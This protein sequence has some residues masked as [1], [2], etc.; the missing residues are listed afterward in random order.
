MTF[1]LAH[2]SDPHLG[3]LPT[4]RVAEL[5]GKRILGFTNWQRRRRSDH[6]ADVLAA[7]V[8]DMRQAAPDHVAVTGDLI[9][10]A[11]EAEFAPAARWLAS[12][13]PAADVT[14]V[15]GNHD[16]YVR[17]AAHH[18]LLHWGSH[19]GHDNVEGAKILDHASHF[20][21]LRRRGPVA[22]IGLST[23]VP[24]APFLATGWLGA[25]QVTRLADLLG[26]LAHEKLFRVVLI[27]HPPRPKPSDRTKH[28]VDAAAFRRVIAA[29]G[30]DLILHGHDHVHALSWLD[31]PAGRVPAVGVPSASGAL[32]GDKDPAGYNLYRID[33]APG[34]W[35]CEAISRGLRRGHDGVV[36]L[37]RRTLIGEP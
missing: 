37:A 33:G 5:A 12:L 25:G 29:H 8:A 19:M 1:V 32:D 2:L 36:D 3:P 15:P 27:H 10:I 11:L 23:A 21:F 30:A 7:I 14:F 28:L 31:G 35:R 18:A 6:R 20:P 9:N 16:A 13:G 34:A 26:R 22:L 17:S 4:P 24:T